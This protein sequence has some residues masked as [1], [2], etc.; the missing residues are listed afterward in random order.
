MTVSRPANARAL[1]SP[2]ITTE[3]VRSS[4]LRSETKAPTKHTILNRLKV[5]LAR[6]GEE[7]TLTFQDVDSVTAEDA[8]RELERIESISKRLTYNSHFSM[9]KLVI[10]PTSVH[11]AHFAWL[12]HEIMTLSTLTLQEKLMPQRWRR[13][14]STSTFFPSFPETDTNNAHTDNRTEQILSA[15]CLHSQRT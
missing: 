4:K 12:V 10:M 8:I 13:Q 3:N 5:E 11:E 7:K 9:F 15:L 2:N 1:G 14:V 6:D